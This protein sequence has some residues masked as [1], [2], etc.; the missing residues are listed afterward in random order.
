MGWGGG[1][2]PGVR[3][4]QLRE[5]GGMV[6]EE[7]NKQQSERLGVTPAT[8]VLAFRPHSWWHRCPHYYDEDTAV[9]STGVEKGP[10]LESDRREFPFPL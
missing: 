1:S 8:P 2:S 9:T 3:E 5:P 7:A 6:A 4:P 10:S